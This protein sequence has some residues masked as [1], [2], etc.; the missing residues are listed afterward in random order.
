MSPESQIYK[1][2]RDYCQE[3]P[4]VKIQGA[5]LFWYARLCFF[6]TFGDIVLHGSRGSAL[7]IAH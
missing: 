6:T 3:L 4:S 2:R 5:R 7:Q 1:V